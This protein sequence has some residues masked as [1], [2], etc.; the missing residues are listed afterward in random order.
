[1]KKTSKMTQPLPTAP[2]LPAPEAPHEPQAL[3]APVP[4]QTVALPPLEGPQM[5]DIVVEEEQASSVQDESCNSSASRPW[6]EPEDPH[7]L[8]KRDRRLSP[9][10]DPVEDLPKP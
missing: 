7:P 3:P 4:P 9:D 8:K 6:V 1:M 10:Y 2:V 5:Q